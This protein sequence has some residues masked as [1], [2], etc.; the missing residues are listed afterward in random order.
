MILFWQFSALDVFFL[1]C[2]YESCSN[3]PGAYL[4]PSHRLTFSVLFLSHSPL[5]Q[6]P[7]KRGS[8]MASHKVC[9]GSCS[10]HNGD[11]FGLHCSF[12]S[13]DDSVVF[14]YRLTRAVWSILCLTST[15]KNVYSSILLGCVPVTS[16]RSKLSKT[17]YFQ[18]RYIC[19]FPMRHW[20]VG[21]FLRLRGRL[22]ETLRKALVQL[23]VAPLQGFG[24][25]FRYSTPSHRK[26]HIPIYV[27]I[28]WELFWGLHFN[29]GVSIV[30]GK[31]EVCL[32]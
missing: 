29:H 8:L 32:F 25:M 1:V 4:V 31:R 3:G 5:S 15:S 18:T 14:V 9:L 16:S 24:F 7:C 19:Y 2:V 13:V 21:A 12:P 11:F 23:I 17:I 20:A 6:V 30:Q 27:K 10:S 26:L 22:L 28:V